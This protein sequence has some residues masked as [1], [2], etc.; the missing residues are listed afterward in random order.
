MLAA[1][2]LVGGAHAVEE[3]TLVVDWSVVE[4]GFV[5]AN[6]MTMKL[7]RECALKAYKLKPGKEESAELHKSPLFD[8]MF[9]RG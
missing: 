9:A 3:A 2:L 7:V 5:E 1:G 4:V 6:I 8:T